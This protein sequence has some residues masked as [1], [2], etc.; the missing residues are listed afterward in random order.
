MTS[1]PDNQLDKLL[2]HKDILA[3]VGIA[4]QLI[5]LGR[6]GAGDVL[7]LLAWARRFLNARNPE[8][9][10]GDILGAELSEYVEKRTGSFFRPVLPT[11]PV[12]CFYFGQEIPSEY[13]CP[14][15]CPLGEKC[16]E[17]YEQTSCLICPE[18][19][20]VESQYGPLCGDCYNAVYEP[21]VVPAEIEGA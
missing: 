3:F 12:D 14:P 11:K 8:A 1:L 17:V 6:E 5:E 9:K 2:Q 20:V 13:H 19:S 16:F 10:A 18:P 15:D 4:G 21:D 7:L